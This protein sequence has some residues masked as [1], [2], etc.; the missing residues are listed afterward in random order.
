MEEGP[1]SSSKNVWE[2]S[3]KVGECLKTVAFL[4]RGGTLDDLCE[5]FGLRCRRDKDLPVVLIKYQQLSAPFHRA[6][7]RECRGLVLEEKTWNVLAYP[8]E[9]FFNVN[10]PLSLK[11]PQLDWSTIRCYEKLDGSLATLYHYNDRWLVA[12]SGTPTGDGLL[13]ETETFAQVES[14][15]IFFFLIF[16]QNL[17]IFWQ[18]WQ[19]EG[20]KLP[21]DTKFNYIFE[22][23]SKKVILYSLMWLIFLSF[24]KRIRL[25]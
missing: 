16:Q 6:V 17:Q 19:K 20:Y 1:A 22:M 14:E 13:N 15:H 18:I 5:E 24:G 25:S 8:Y 11:G 9:K 21:K 10:E 7:T 2:S 4:K 23:I 3:A 12:S